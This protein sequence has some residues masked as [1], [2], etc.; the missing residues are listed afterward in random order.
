MPYLLQDV[1]EE[2]DPSLDPV[3]SKQVIKIGSREIMRLGDKELD[4]DWNFK[5]FVTTKLANPHYSPEMSTKVTIV[6]F[7]VKE[8]GLVAQLLALVVQQEQ[9]NL[10]H[11]TRN[12]SIL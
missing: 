4:Y 2:I 5:F 12:S 6:N 9:P 1:L 11:A 7:A 3:L 10:R 8:D